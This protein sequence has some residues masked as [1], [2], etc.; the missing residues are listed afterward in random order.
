MPTPID[1]GVR[2]LDSAST[3]F[4]HHDEQWDERLFTLIRA[5]RLI[6]GHGGPPMED[7][8]ILIAGDRI[9]AV[10]RVGSVRAPE[11]ATVQE[12]HYEEMTVLPGLIDTHVHLVGTGDGRSGDELAMQPDDILTLQAAKNARTHLY[13]G[14]TTACDCGGK[15]QTTPRLR[16][17]MEMGVTPGPSLL[18]A[19]Q[20]ISAIA[21]HLCYF[22]L[23]A[24]GPD[25]CRA[26]VRQLVKE[27]ADFI[28][29][30]VT[31]GDTRTMPL[32]P[33]LTAEELKAICDEAHELGQHTVAHC[34]STQGMVNALD[35]GADTITHG[36]FREP[37]GTYL[38]RSDVAERIVKQEVFVNPTLHSGRGRTH[39]L[40]VALEQEGLTPDEQFELDTLHKADEART[41]C[42]ARMKAI[43]VRLICGSNSGRDLYPMGGFQHEIEAHAGAGMTPMEAIVSATRD[44]ARACRLDNS[45]GTLE[46][47]KLADIL[48]V[49][50]DPSQSISAL[51]DVVDVFRAGEM[52]DRGNYL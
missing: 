23:E 17:A 27:G 11:G 19:I 32:R 18:L 26:A 41:D 13:S 49:D 9:S 30:T 37:D 2:A 45:V 39:S 29:L 46:A 40:E 52:V 22:G 14:V 4:E 44:A 3:G 28:K 15:N 21:G 16:Q 31:G 48:V 36:L 12:F 24:T 51:W 8:A 6:D 38:F 7:G 25:G 33:S 10:G 5:R 42:I 1:T 35:A 43:G 20:P 50:G 34:A 47:G